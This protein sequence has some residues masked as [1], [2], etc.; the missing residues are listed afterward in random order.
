MK[1]QTIALALAL[2]FG[3][4]GHAMAQTS[5]N[6]VTKTT[7]IDKTQRVDAIIEQQN[8]IRADIKASHNGWDGLSQDKRDEVL[9]DQDRLFVLLQGK[10]TIGDLAP[11][12]QVDAANLLES[13]KAIALNA[14]DERMVCTRERKMGSNFTQRVCRTVGQ[15][16][17][18]REA[19]R[20]GLQRAD[21]MQRM[22]PKQAGSL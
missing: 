13:I 19:A 21:Q 14:E 22:Q 5:M 6:V 12:R 7:T 20:D 15:L 3:G 10:Q 8:Q 11:D 1:I 16:R 18:E 17:R 2:A 9:R 4:A